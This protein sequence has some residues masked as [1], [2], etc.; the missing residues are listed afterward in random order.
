M[1]F[2]KDLANGKNPVIKV[3]LDQLTSFL[4]E[5][6]EIN[7]SPDCLYNCGASRKFY[8]KYLIA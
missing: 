6:H 5:S 3:M 1:Q 4:N 7:K 8:W 2:N